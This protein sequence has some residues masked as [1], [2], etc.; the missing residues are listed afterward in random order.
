MFHP[1]HN[2]KRHERFLDFSGSAAQYYNIPTSSVSGGLG[3]MYTFVFQVCSA[4][5]ELQPPVVLTV[6]QNSITMLLSD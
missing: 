3:K 4:R 5:R 1:A 2:R 6:V